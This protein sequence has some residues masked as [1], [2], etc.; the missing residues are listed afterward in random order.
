MKKRKLNFKRVFL[1][2]FI[3]VIIAAGCIYILKINDLDE[4]ILKNNIIKEKIYS[5]FDNNISFNDNYS[6]TDFINVEEKVTDF[7]NL[8]YK[9]IYYLKTNDFTTFFEDKE[10]NEFY[11]FNK[12]L[13]YQINMRLEEEN[14]LKLKNAFYNIEFVSIE[15]NNGNYEVVVN[16]DSEVNFVFMKDI[17]TKFYNVE[18]I[19]V[20][21]SEYK[22]ISYRRSQDFYLAF[23]EKVSEAFT[24]EE[25]DTLST[26]YS[27][28]RLINI[29]DRKTDY[30]IY[31]ENKEYTSPICDNT[32][33][34]TKALEYSKKYI[35]ERNTDDWY[36]FDNFGGNCQNYAS[37]VVYAGGIPMDSTGTVW[38]YYGT[39]PNNEG[40]KTGRSAS[41]TIVG[42]FYNYAKNNTGYGLC[43]E[44]DI[45]PYYA[46]PGDIMQLGNDGFFVH[47]IVVSGNVTKDDNVIDILVNS[48]TN[49]YE[50]VPISAILSPE[51]RLIKINGWNN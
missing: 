49:D 36:S 23:S 32:Y 51:I 10:S 48:N 7:L 27:T 11:L 40:N 2:I 34:R 22:L 39:T 25:I 31:L 24:K 14:D 30:T 41:W 46:L 28:K 37:Q 29:E 18:N 9:S 42:D 43:A 21:N 50:N 5:K 4:K 17:T 6:P 15:E 44:V 3:L 47:T 20:F 13:E 1:L 12:A 38:K 8:Y 33:D 45:N 26:E 19:F 16:E 35:N